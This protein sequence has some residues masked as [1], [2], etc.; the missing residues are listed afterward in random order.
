MI[1]W[2]KQQTLQ[3]ML[4]PNGRMA[5]PTELTTFPNEISLNVP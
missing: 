1:S 4:S 5:H 2:N 3:N